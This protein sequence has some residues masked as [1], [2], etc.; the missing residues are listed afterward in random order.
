MQWRKRQCR[1]DVKI[2]PN[3]FGAGK[4]TVMVLVILS[5]IFGRQILTKVFEPTCAHAR[6]A[7]MIRFLSVRLLL[8]QKD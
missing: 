7:L 8:D 1:I 6:W 5:I 4:V 2:H 3:Y